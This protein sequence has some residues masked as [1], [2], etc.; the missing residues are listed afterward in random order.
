MKGG[1]RDRT[2]DLAAL[3]DEKSASH[4]GWMKE[5]DRVAEGLEQLKQAEV[6]VLW[7]PFH[8]MNGDWF[9]GTARTRHVYQI[10]AADVRLLHER[11]KVGQLVVGVQSESW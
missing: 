5:L 4:A 11:E 7:R 8:E 10:V 2:V 3:L 1:L 9:C 6:V